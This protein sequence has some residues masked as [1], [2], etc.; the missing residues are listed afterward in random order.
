[1]SIGSED[2]ILGPDRT[3]VSADNPCRAGRIPFDRLGGRPGE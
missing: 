2:N 1:M 3:P